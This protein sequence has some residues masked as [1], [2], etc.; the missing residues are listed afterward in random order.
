MAGG[1][2]LRPRAPRWLDWLLCSAGITSVACLV[3]RV[4]LSDGDA[5]YPSLSPNT[6]LPRLLGVAVLPVLLV[7][8]LLEKAA[9]RLV[10]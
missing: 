8:T 5:A 3:W 4:L 10:E 7:V 1:R 6:L 9:R 2:D